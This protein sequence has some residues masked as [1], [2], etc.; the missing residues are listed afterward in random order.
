MAYNSMAV[1]MGNQTV[2][3]KPRRLRGSNRKFPNLNRL[4]RAPYKR[5]RSLKSG[6]K[7]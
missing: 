7:P 5:K 6:L 1:C 4:A 3:Y 2:V